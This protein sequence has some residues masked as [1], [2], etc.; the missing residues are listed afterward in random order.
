LGVFFYVEK[1][2][3][4]TIKSEGKIKPSDDDGFITA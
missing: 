1:K 3:L 2:I 4:K